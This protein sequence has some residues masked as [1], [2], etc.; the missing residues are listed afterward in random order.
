M[1][2]FKRLN[3]QMDGKGFQILLATV[4]ALMGGILF[5]VPKIQ[6]ITLCI[7][8]A[9]GLI[10]LGIV[11]ITLF[12][13]LK[14]YL[15]PR[16]LRFSGGV[17]LILLGIVAILRL[18]EMA[19][20][21]EFY[22]GVAAL[23]LAAGLLQNAIQL[24]VLG[25]KLWILSLILTLAAGTTATLVLINYRPVLEAITGF[26]YLTLLISGLASLLSTLLTTFLLSR[27]A[28]RK[29]EEPTVEEEEDAYD[30]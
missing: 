21:V 20:S 27:H 28:H 16:N 13:A 2:I 6:V 8:L 24:R 17:L 1:N 7:V 22:L 10:V 14:G 26:G 4:A 25:A 30:A 3:A 15:E 11:A 23:V 29:P 19:N 18:E 5:F 12:F 9:I